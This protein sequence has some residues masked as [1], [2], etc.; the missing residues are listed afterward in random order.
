MTMVG[1]GLKQKTLYKVLTPSIKPPLQI[2]MGLW[3][4]LGTIGC[5]GLNN[6]YCE[7]VQDVQLLQAAHKPQHLQAVTTLAVFQHLR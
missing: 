4:P 3:V 7:S 2:I 6:N 5:I 1:K